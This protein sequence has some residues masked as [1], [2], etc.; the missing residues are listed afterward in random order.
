MC[1]KT[2]HNLLS[3]LLS[4]YDT[5]GTLICESLEQTFSTLWWESSFLFS[6]HVIKEKIKLLLCHLSHF[7]FL[8]TESPERLELC[9][10][11]LQLSALRVHRINTQSLFFEKQFS[12]D[13]ILQPIKIHSRVYYLFVL[14]LKLNQ[15]SSKLFGTCFE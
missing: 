8:K 12:S 6:K 2:D 14:I 11:D 4:Q 13:C 15:Q 10:S 9:F 5:Q 1:S 3:P 7:F